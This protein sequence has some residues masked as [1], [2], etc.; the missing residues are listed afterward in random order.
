MTASTSIE[1][2]ELPERV[3]A[4]PEIEALREIAARVPAY[5]VG[6]VVRDLLLG[7]DGVDVDV[8]IEGDADALSDLPGFDLEREG[9]FLTSR[10]VR[11]DL[12]VD[13]ARARAESYL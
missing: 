4:L 1:P 5:L 7:Y 11:D 10:L 3:E 6:G 2:Q 8:A 12:R 13:I 9:L